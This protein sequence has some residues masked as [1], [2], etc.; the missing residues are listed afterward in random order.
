M[1]YFLFWGVE[2][3]TKFSKKVTWQGL[4]FKR[5]TV[6]KEGVNF[7]SMGREGLQLLYKKLKSEILNEKKY[8]KPKCLS[9][10]TKN[11]N[12]QILTKNLVTFER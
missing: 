11:L 12:C 8:Y 3:P 7:L 4:S 6:E 2:S 5:E 9:A 10:M 1:I